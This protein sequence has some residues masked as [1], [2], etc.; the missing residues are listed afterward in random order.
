MT[1]T[2]ASTARAALAHAIEEEHVARQNLADAR[3]AVDKAKGHAWR[4]ESD[5]DKLHRQ[6]EEPPDADAM[7]AQI[8]AGDV[9][10]LARPASELRSRIAD[11]E[12]HVDVWRKARAVAEQSIPIREEALDWA[13]TRVANAV[14]AVVAGETNI[15]A[16]IAVTVE[17][18]ETA[19]RRRAALLGV[20]RSLAHGS[21]E[22]RRLEDF[23]AEAWLAPL[24]DLPAAVAWEAARTALKADPN[25]PLP[26]S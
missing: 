26:T 6:A 11:G 8:A 22:R 19:L 21:A 9:A 18:Q 24:E 23:L 1:K 12:E 2:E 17:A 14:S 13:Q 3:A 4:A 16:M 7:L 15:D 10:E 20:A 5:L 25:A